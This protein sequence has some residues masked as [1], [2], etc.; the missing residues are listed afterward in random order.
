MKKLLSLILAC[1]M[2]A[3]C[4]FPAFALS[5][6]DISALKSQFIDGIGPKANGYALDY[7]YYSPVKEADTQKYPLVIWLHGLGQGGSPRAQIS[8]NYFP[9]WASEELQ[10]RFNGTG[11]AFLMAIRSKDDIGEFWSTNLIPSAKAAIDDFIAKN[12]A[13]IDTTRIYIGGFSMGGKMTIRMAATYP[14][15]FAAA[16]PICPAES[17][18]E[19]QLSM[20]KDM[21]VWLTV[22]KYDVLAGYYTYSENVWKGLC[23]TSSNP[24]NLRLSLL[25]TVKYPNGKKTPSNHH[26]W[27]A[28]TADMFTYENG[29]YYNMQT[30]DGNGNDVTLTYPEGMISWL[31]SFTSD[32]HGESMEPTGVFPEKEVMTFSFIT[33]LAPMIKSIFKIVFSFASDPLK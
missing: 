3:V 30:I 7:V 24:D 22:S 23:K 28:V 1:I 31:S 17:A 14:E 19:K 11:G 16:F 33:M 32:Y 4:V 8:D 15:M 20:L 12:E 18:S 10:S 2:T 5:E 9:Y 6:N 13:N 29:D 21:P 27:F 25:G 26:A